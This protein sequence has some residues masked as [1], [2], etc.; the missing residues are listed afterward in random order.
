M[1]PSLREDFLEAVIVFTERQKSPPSAQEIAGMLHLPKSDA[2]MH[3]QEL[4]NLGDITLRPDGGIE[5]TPAGQMIGQQTIKKH[6]T[7]QCF[8]TEIL[9]MDSSM[10]SDEACR[11][12]HTVSD[13]T[14]DRLGDYLR[15]P[16]SQPCG[17][18]GGHPARF[19]IRGSPRNSSC[20]SGMSLVDFMEGDHLIV[21]DILGRGCQKRLLDLG[22]VPGQQIVIRRKLNNKAVVVHVK[23][24]DVALSP[25]VASAICVEKVP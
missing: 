22:V 10:A 16:A 25:E 19:C 17:G 4:L 18:P 15:T 24:C 13:E 23:D 7:L 5:L 14:I 2:D 8:L 6:E 1:L 20:G 11:I 3:V 21:R 12:E 9:G